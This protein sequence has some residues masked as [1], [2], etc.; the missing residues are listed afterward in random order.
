MR[1]ARPQRCPHSLSSC[2]CPD[3]VLNPRGPGRACAKCAVLD[4]CAAWLH[5]ATQCADRE[6]GWLASARWCVCANHTAGKMCEQDNYMYKSKCCK[7]RQ[8]PGGYLV[9]TASSCLPKAHTHIRPSPSTAMPHMQSTRQK[10]A[11][12]LC[13]CSSCTCGLPNPITAQI[14]R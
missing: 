13:A 12:C 6:A 11:C 1:S 4:P 5:R 3:V 2:S 7:S 8:A 14:T 9:K 10:H